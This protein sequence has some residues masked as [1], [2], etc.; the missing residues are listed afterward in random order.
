MTTYNT[1]VKVV[2]NYFHTVAKSW[3]QLYE[4][5]GPRRLIPL[6]LA[7]LGGRRPWA[8]FSSSDPVTFST[9]FTVIFK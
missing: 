6:V 9:P 2:H 8:P 3:K 5:Q 1:R 4:Y 7:L